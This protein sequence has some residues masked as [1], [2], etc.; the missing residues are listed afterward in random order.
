[1]YA[2]MKELVQLQEQGLLFFQLMG[3]QNIA[4]MVSGGF[5]GNSDDKDLD[6]HIASHL[7]DRASAHC[8]KVSIGEIGYKRLSK[9]GELKGK[10]LHERMADVRQEIY[11]W[12]LKPRGE[13][14]H[15]NPYGLPCICQWEDLEVLCGGD[16]TTYNKV[17]DFY[18][19]SWWVPPN[20]GG[21]ITGVR[22]LKRFADP[23]A[24]HSSSTY[25]PWLIASVN[26][27]KRVDGNNDGQISVGE[28]ERFASSN[29]K[30]NQKWVEENRRSG[31]GCVLD[32][33][34]IHYNHT[35]VYGSM[36][37]TMHAECQQR[38]SPANCPQDRWA[39]LATI[40]QEPPYEYPCTRAGSLPNSIQAGWPESWPV[41]S[42]K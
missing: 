22:K 10:P 27:I 39:Y 36:I 34:R 25:F 37:I 28:F 42:N 21:K 6:V 7:H 2:C 12:S 24:P 16:T 32:N 4:A 40:W 31:N 23:R 1:M 15:G 5:H 18:G 9:P 19:A 35:L 41:D 38:Q 8:S 3:G 33:A 17:E 20:S 13:Y 11:R 30:V 29:P 14:F 26:G